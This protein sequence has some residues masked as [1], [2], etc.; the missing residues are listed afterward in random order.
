MLVTNKYDTLRIDSGNPTRELCPKLD[1]TPGN[2]EI[3]NSEG[4]RE[5]EDDRGLDTNQRRSMKSC[6]YNGRRRG[7]TEA[8][9]P[10]QCV[11][12]Y[13]YDGTTTCQYQLVFGYF[14]RVRSPA[15]C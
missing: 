1:S 7:H 13:C 11:R 6:M 4:L 2:V 9:W 8:F 5:A 10:E 14:L 3:E 12:C 15:Q